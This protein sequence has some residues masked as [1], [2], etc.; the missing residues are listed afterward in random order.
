MPDGTDS[1]TKAGD[2]VATLNHL[3]DVWQML[4]MAP[5]ISMEAYLE[6]RGLIERA[7]A[8]AGGL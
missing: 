1:G 3:R 6:V 4:A 5:N 7:T 8:M 2:L